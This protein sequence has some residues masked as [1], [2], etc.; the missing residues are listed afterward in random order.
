MFSLETWNARID[1]FI[2][3]EN[4]T[5][6]REMPVYRIYC[7]DGNDRSGGGLYNETVTA[8]TIG[9]FARALGDSNPLYSDPSYARLRYGAG[10][11]PAISAPGAANP[12][13][14]ISASGAADPNPA[15]SASGAPVSSAA[16]QQY[17]AADAPASGFRALRAAAASPAGIAAPPL[18]ECCICSTFIGGR[19]PRLRG[20]TVFDAGTKWERFAPILAGDTFSAVTRSLGVR[21]ITKNEQIKK[22]A[23]DRLLVRSHEIDLKNQRGELVSRL[24]A[25]SMIRCAAPQADQEKSAFGKNE[26]PDVCEKT[27]S[28]ADREEA[29]SSAASGAADR[30]EAGSSA[31]SGAADR[32]VAASAAGARPRYTQ[33]QL[34]RIYANLDAQFDGKFRRGDQIRY[35]EDVETGEELPD[36]AAGPYDESDGQSLMAAI[37]VS[38]AFAT[39][40]GTLRARRGG[41]VTD[42]ETGARRLPIDRHNSDLIARTQGLPRALVSGIHSQT[43]LAKSVGDWM[44]DAGMLRSLDCRCK[45]PLYFGDVTTQR[46]RVTGKYVRDGRFFVRLKMEAVRQDGV[47][48]TEA[49]AEVELPRRI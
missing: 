48:H 19:L 49:E 31:S 1:A 8:D 44:G 26:S 3:E 45:K 28:L 33:D 15:I 12:V 40:W 9:R 37:G 36:Q 32:E 24:T 35:W 34:D 23:V 30:E 43:L 17:G 14:A 16:W 4:Q 20:V 47:V 39:K 42:P 2:E 5:V 38:N 29:G 22:E 21:E 10:D 41:Q 46:G 18:L 6:G 13:P 27:D 25:R 11:G 7:Q